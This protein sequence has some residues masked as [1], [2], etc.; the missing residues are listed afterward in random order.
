MGCRIQNGLLQISIMSE[1]AGMNSWLTGRTSSLR[2]GDDAWKFL[3]VVDACKWLDGSSLFPYSVYIL[4][5]CILKI[6]R[7]GRWDKRQNHRLNRICQTPKLVESNGWEGL[8]LSSS[9]V[10]SSHPTCYWGLEWLVSSLTGN[11]VGL[12]ACW[13]T[14]LSKGRKKRETFVIN[15][16]KYCHAVIFLI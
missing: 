16:E 7:A 1:Y 10:P 2:L 5:W 3:I 9:Q 14:L 8:W 15:C 12:C 11:A 4:T 13:C 6:Y